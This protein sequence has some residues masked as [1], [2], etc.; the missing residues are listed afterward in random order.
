MKDIVSTTNYS[1]SG[2]NPVPS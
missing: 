1:W 2:F